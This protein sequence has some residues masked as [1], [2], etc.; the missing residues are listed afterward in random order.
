ML[1][2]LWDG[3]PSFPHTLNNS[4]EYLLCLWSILLRLSDGTAIWRIAGNKF[5]HF[6]ETG[7]TGIPRL[8]LT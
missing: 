6:C 5:H 7:L 8:C 4:Y 1:P 3:Q 2:V